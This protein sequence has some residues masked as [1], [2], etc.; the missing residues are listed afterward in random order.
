MGYK[1]PQTRLYLWHPTTEILAYEYL[2]KS[3]NLAVMGEMHSWLRA[4]SC[5]RREPGLAWP[6]LPNNYNTLGSTEVQLEG[7]SIPTEAL[8]LPIALGFLQTFTASKGCSAASATTSIEA[9]LARSKNS[10]A[11]QDRAF[12]SPGLVEFA[13]TSIR[14]ATSMENVVFF[15]S[16]TLLPP[17]ECSTIS[18]AKGWESRIE[19]RTGDDKGLAHALESL[20]PLCES[21]DALN[22]EAI[23]D[24]QRGFLCCAALKEAWQF[25]WM[26][27]TGRLD[28]GDPP[29]YPS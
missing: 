20:L 3:N 23:R 6:L 29:P 17:D 28:S 1:L 24:F 25:A 7:S 8:I 12:A 5:C 19:R 21:D 22:H 16:S 14:L 2:T 13:S 10:V 27:R 15:L 18:G 11:S 26:M 9:E 4:F